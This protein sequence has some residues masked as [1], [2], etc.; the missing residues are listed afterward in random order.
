ML[1]ENDGRILRRLERKKT[2]RYDRKRTR[3]VVNMSEQVALVTGASR[4]IG[5]AVARAL[6]AQGYCVAVH[7][8]SRKEDALAVV[9]SLP[10]SSGSRA[11]EADVSTP[12]GCKSLVGEVKKEFGRIDVLVNNA[13]ISI[14]QLLSFAKPQEL[15]QVM[16][17]NFASVF[18][19][20]KAVSR[21]M[22]RRKSGRIINMSSVVGHTGNSGQSMYAASKGAVTAFSKSAAGELAE[23]GI[24]VNCVAPG[25]IDTEMTSELGAE[26][27][28]RISATIPV[29]RLGK[30][31][32]VAAA[33]VFLASEGA[34]YVTG[35]TIHVNG[36]MHMG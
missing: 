26:V 7:Y 5:A 17:T 31:E 24:L 20:T 32:E 27:T 22:I 3:E 6:A 36:G 9:N 28:S 35:T 21:V 33:V 18:H 34:S 25:F 2:T 29:G 13:G 14:D 11:F 30:P 15:D 12:E 1:G 19:M 23:H 16:S 8:R 10:E 4:G